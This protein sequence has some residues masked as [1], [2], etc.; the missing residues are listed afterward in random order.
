MNP[1]KKKKR[2]RPKTVP[3][4]NCHFRSDRIN[5][6]LNHECHVDYGNENSCKCLGKTCGGGR[7]QVDET[8]TGHNG[9]S[10]PLRLSCNRVWREDDLSPTSPLDHPSEGFRFRG[11]E[12]Q[13]LPLPSSPS[14]RRRPDRLQNERPL[15]STEVLF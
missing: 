11:P 14:P 6:S 3:S 13:G 10:S 5:V 2:P 9:Y 4:F 12:G 15:V 8:T 1:K 7:R